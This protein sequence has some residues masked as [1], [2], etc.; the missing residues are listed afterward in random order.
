MQE[1]QGTVL[2]NTCLMFVNNM[3]SGS[4]HDSTKVPLLTVGGL[5][6]KLKTGQVLDYSKKSDHE[7]KLCSFYLSIMN[8]MDVQATAF[9]DAETPLVD[10][11]A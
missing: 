1:G 7:R 4:K 2:D 11:D 8:R 3:W 9:G 10:L 5:G 6:G